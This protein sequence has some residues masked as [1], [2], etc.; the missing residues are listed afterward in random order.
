MNEIHN[1]ECPGPRGEA[2]ER[3]LALVTTLGPVMERWLSEHG[4]T[5]ARATVIWLLHHSGPVTQRELSQAL[6]VTPR[7]VTGLLDALQTTGYVTRDAHPTDRRAVLVGLSEQGRALAQRLQ[8]GYGELGQTLFGEVPA[9]D[10][11]G[12]ISTLDHVVAQLH[13]LDVVH[14]GD[15]DVA[16]GNRDRSAQ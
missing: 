15:T 10:L 7:N 12:F 5:R 13:D 16:R 11:G 14:L 8:S 6:R 4:L 1:V 9:A 2:L 3:L